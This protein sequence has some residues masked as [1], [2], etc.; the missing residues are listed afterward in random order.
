MSYLSLG[1]HLKPRVHQHKDLRPLSILEIE[2]IIYLLSFWALFYPIIHP[3]G[4]SKYLHYQQ[5][6]FD[7]ERT[8]ECNSVKIE[9][10]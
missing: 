6:N 4:K 5:S 7:E 2:L 3:L 10:I 9:K 1:G 8:V